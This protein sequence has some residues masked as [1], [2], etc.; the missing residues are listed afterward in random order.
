MP[1]SDPDKQREYQRK[2]MQRKDR[3]RPIVA[4]QRFFYIR[5]SKLKERARNKGIGFDLSGEYLAEIWPEDSICPALKI[6][7][8]KGTEGVSTFCSPSIDRINP[9]LGYIKGNVQW[10]SFL[11]NLIMSNATADQVIMVGEY[12]KKITK[13]LENEKA[14][15]QR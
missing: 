12:F 8:E 11:A 7:M 10:V 9:N 1:Y 14:F 15:Q 2:W 13:E 3:N 6:K 5:S 4:T